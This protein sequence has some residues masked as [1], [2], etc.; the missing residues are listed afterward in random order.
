MGGVQASDRTTCNLW[1]V[2]LLTVGL[3]S[4]S[5][6]LLLFGLTSQLALLQGHS[7]ERNQE[8]LPRRKVQ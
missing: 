1:Q 2:R 3:A 5:G 7:R 8:K 4:L 6:I